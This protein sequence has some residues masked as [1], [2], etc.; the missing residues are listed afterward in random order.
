MLGRLGE[1]VRGDIVACSTCPTPM[2]FFIN[3]GL[4]LHDRTACRNRRRTMLEPVIRRPGTYAGWPADHGDCA[5][6]SANGDDDFLLESLFLLER[7]P[8]FAST[9]FCFC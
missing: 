2:L 8:K 9:V 3:G 4:L 1:A 7:A 6:W 5:R